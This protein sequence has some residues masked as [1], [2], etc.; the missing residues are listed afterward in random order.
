MNW[1]GT[2]NSKF[3]KKI[4]FNFD[5]GSFYKEFTFKKMFTRKSFV[6]VF[7]TSKLEIKFHSHKKAVSPKLENFAHLFTVNFKRAKFQKN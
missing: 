4:P 3:Y 5:L 7:P 2:S 6:R 1:S